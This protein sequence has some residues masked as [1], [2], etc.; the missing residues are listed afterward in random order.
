MRSLLKVTTVVAAVALHLNPALAQDARLLPFTGEWVGTGEGREWPTAPWEPASCE[1]T[2]EWRRGL[3]SYGVCEG[4]RGRFSAGGT[5]TTDPVVSGTFLVPH[6]VDIT[7]PG[8]ELRGDALVATYAY[9]SETAV[10]A[11]RLTVRRAGD[12]LE[13]R[14]EALIEGRWHEVGRVVLQPR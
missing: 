1:I 7:D 9:E 13:M 8:V 14:T 3:Q 12:T 2:I 11:F 10:Y 6:F 5:V 4:A